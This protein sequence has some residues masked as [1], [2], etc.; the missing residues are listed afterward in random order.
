MQVCSINK[1]KGAAVKTAAAL[2]C[3]CVL[4]LAS[5]GGGG[6][7]V[8]TKAK[9]AENIT[10]LPVEGLSDDFIMGVDVSSLISLENAGVVYYDAN[11]NK[12]DVL[13]LLKAGGANCV[14]VRV[15]NDPH[16][17]EGNSYG[18]GNCDIDNAVEIGK[19]VMK[20]GMDFMVD[21]HYSD[22]W[23]DPN[24]QKSPKAW[25]DMSVEQKVVA[26]QEYTTECLQ[27]LK[28][29]G[30]KVKIVQVGNEINLGMAGEVY[31]ED[32]YV[33]V[34]A[35]CDAVRK[36]DS[37]IEIS[38]HYTNPLSEGSDGLESKAPLLEEYEVDYDILSTSYYSYWHGDVNKLG[39]TLKRLSN[40]YGKKVMVA[41]TSYPF[42]DDDGDGYGNVVSTMSA[43][44]EYN[45]PFTVEGQAIAVRD[46][47]AAV[48][49]VKKGAGVFY[50]EPAWIPVK[51]WDYDADDAEEVL[52]SNQEAWEKYGC[53]WASSYAAEYDK[54]VRM[55]FNGGSWDNQAFFDFDGKCLD[56]IN[57]FNYVRTGSKG[58]LLVVR[59][60]DP[61]VEFAFGKAEKLP[62]TVKVAYND[63]VEKDEPVKWNERQAEIVENSPDFGEY[64]VFGTLPNGDMVE[65][66]VTVTASNFLTNGDFETGDT[67]GWTIV[68]D[69][70]KGSP[71]VDQ[72]SQNAKKGLCYF[73]AWEPDD[74]EM[75]IYQT[76]EGIAAGT[77]KCFASFESTGILNPSGTVFWAEI[78]R[79]DGSTERFADDVEF[80][81][82]WKSFYTSE[83]PLLKIDGTVESVSVGCHVKAE[84]DPDTGA[85]GAW[86]VMDDVNL[87]LVE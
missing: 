33:L 52:E 83:L 76:I 7:K 26:L 10:V 2:S 50:W 35:G 43:N 71:R 54:E 31:D 69:E 1:T 58:P 25:E 20:A 40:M 30:V 78:K 14:R 34:K 80:P 74:Y 73:T 79:T 9:D 81:N 59:H 8:A 56:S 11:G 3:A 37:S 36:F 84:F 22:F 44:N 38:I 39:V 24:K 47:I 4:L 32:V 57:V 27:K 45:Y 41:E 63:G 29:A 70:G 75:D 86:F 55:E 64:S 72:N 6:G 62:Q 5:C 67:S 82:Q 61:R 48:A 87:L 28:D 60:E 13:D 12:A 68:N 46:V 16:D 49:S 23:A 17:E 19:R 85:N 53:G 18:G 77:Y 51:H 21:F 15:W 66:T 42:S 65:C